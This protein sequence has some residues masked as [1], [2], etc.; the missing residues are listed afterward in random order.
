RIHEIANYLEKNTEITKDSFVR[1]TTT[2]TNEQKS[3]FPLLN[4]LPVNV[5]LEGYLFPDTYR[6]FKNASVKDIINKML[7]T[8]ESKITD[9]MRADVKKQGKTIHEIL[10]MASL[11]E[12]EV[13]SKEDMQIVSGIFWNRV[14]KGMRLESDATLSY[15]FDDN[16]SAHSGDALKAETPYNSYKYEGLPPTPIGN[17]G[18]N[19]INAAI[20]PTKTNYFYF[21]SGNDG[22][23]Y[24]AETYNAH[25]KNKKNHLN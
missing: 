21:L 14:N 2:V 13:R 24:Y 6:I 3:S 7:T 1:N 10:T 8:L 4:S 22:T 20:Y 9:Q 25:L 15:Y 17:P 19:A 23:T 16:L 5:N 18:L 11:I 12:K